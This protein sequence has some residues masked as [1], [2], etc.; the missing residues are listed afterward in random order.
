MLRREKTAEVPRPGRAGMVAVKSPPRTRVRSVPTLTLVGVGAGAAAAAWLEVSGFAGYLA[1]ALAVAVFVQLSDASAGLRL[2]ATA[3]TAIFPLL[4]L[5]G[6]EAGLLW[7]SAF[8]FAAL[9]VASVLMGVARGLVSSLAFSVLV[10]IYPAVLACHLILIKG[11]PRGSA[12]V[13]AY[14]FMAGGYLAVGSLVERFRASRPDAGP[15]GQILRL[16]WLA[17]VAGLFAAQAIAFSAR[18][19]LDLPLGIVAVAILALVVSAA[20]AVGDLIGVF[21][22]EERPDRR[23]GAAAGLQ[24]LNAVLLAAPAFYYGFRLYLS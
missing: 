9:A 8:A 16:G 10:V 17:V 15:R 12:M 21:L 24:Y 23:G 4:V 19:L 20:A 5:Q 14:L 18:A 6:G 7:G 1:A 3:C 2:P 11:F 13:L 22:W